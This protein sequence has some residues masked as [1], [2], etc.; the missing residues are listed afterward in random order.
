MIRAVQFIREWR[1]KMGRNDSRDIELTYG[2]R[3]LLVMRGFARWDE[4]EENPAPNTIAASQPNAG[5]APV[6]HKFPKKAPRET[7]VR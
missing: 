1:G 2:Q 6:P 7:V 4:P 3:E 5:Y